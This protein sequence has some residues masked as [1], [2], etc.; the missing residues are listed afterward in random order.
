MKVLLYNIYALYSQDAEYTFLVN[1][2]ILIFRYYQLCLSSY[3]GRMMCFEDRI[4]N[5]PLVL[6]YDIMI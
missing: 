6:W 5:Q 2:L 1:H 4:L 3:Q